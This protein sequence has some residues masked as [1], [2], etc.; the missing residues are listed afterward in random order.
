M[1]KEKTQEA[2]ERKIL[3]IYDGEC[4]VCRRL[5]EKAEKWEYDWK[6]EW[7]SCH[8]SLK[9]GELPIT[10][11]PED[12]SKALHVVDEK[13]RVFRGIQAIGFLLSKGKKWKALVGYLLGW[14]PFSW[15]AAAGYRLFAACRHWF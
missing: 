1:S 7:I 5:K 4:T 10:L 3:V 12:V 14:P 13:G 11:S 9:L 8:D 15:I 2:K 6:V